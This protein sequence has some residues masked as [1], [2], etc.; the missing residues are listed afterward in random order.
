MAHCCRLANSA[1]PSSLNATGVFGAIYPSRF[2]CRRIGGPCRNDIHIVSW[3]ASKYHILLDGS[4]RGKWI[5]V[6]VMYG[7]WRHRL[8]GMIDRRVLPMEEMKREP[9]SSNACT[10]WS[11]GQIVATTQYSGQGKCKSTSRD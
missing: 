3:D 10:P 2:A 8:D 5:R 4:E 9:G 6:D 1:F 7:D 11:V